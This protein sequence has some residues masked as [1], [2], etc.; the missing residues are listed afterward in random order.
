MDFQTFSPELRYALMHH[1]WR[2]QKKEML[3]QILPL[4]VSILA[5]SARPHEG[6]NAMEYVR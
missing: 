4:V 3:I 2:I 5:D 6:C 1:D